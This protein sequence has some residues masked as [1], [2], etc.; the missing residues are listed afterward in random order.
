MKTKKE[1]AAS[2]GRMTRLVVPLRWYDF[3]PSKGSR[4]KRP[5]EYKLVLVR[6]IAGDYKHIEGE[7]R[8]VLNEGLPPGLAVGYRKN[9]AG[10]K[11]SPYFVVPGIGGNVSAWCDCLPSGLTMDHF[12]HNSLY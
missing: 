12:R 2:S 6:T 4:Q 8:F 3:D 5:P 11:Q 1:L 9:A 7:I 10:D